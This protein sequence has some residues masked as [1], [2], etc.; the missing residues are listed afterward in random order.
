VNIS[1]VSGWLPW[2]VR[3]LAVALL[4]VV[5]D[6]RSVDG[7]RHIGRGVLIAVLVTG[8][9][10]VVLTV[11][12]V[13][14]SDLPWSAVVWGFTFVLAVC[15]TVIH[16][17][18]AARWRRVAAVAAVVLTLLVTLD[19][20][21]QHSGSFPT[22]GRLVSLDPENVVETPQLKQIRAQVAATGVLPSQ[23]VVFT[24]TI[25]AKVS[26]FATRPAT[27]YLPPAW[28]AKVTPSLPTLV[29]LPGEPGSASD[30]SNDGDADNTA[31]AFANAHHGVAPIIVMPDP[32]GLLTDDTECVNSKFGNA[33]T[34]LVEDV[35]AFARSQY[36]ASDSV[37]SLAIAGLSAGG[38]CSVMLALRHPQI[39]PTFASYSGFASPQFEETTQAETID[40]LFGGSEDA[41]AAHDPAELLRGGHFDGMAG[42]FEVGNQDV[43]PAEAARSLQA[44]ASGAG[45][46]TC[47]LVRPGGHDYGLWSQ[48]L[49]D[50]F[51]WLAWRLGLTA[52]PAH[53]PASCTSP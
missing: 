53:E 9:A 5:V 2:V 21:D 47:I 7:R 16:W 22:L 43:V 45:I 48:A 17:R 19:T 30:W 25:P 35:P 1:I 27:I 31:D 8:A 34:Y 14:P 24:V 13:I 44:A 33:E 15:L 18:G 26:H 36:N 51:P 46:S 20:V 39:Y 3:C 38:T 49:V 40:I 50:S 10:T 11:T 52:A 23:G 41:F 32:N 12:S 37:G 42:W 6:W 29:L 28:F 4:V